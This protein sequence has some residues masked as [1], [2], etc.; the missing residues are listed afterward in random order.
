MPKRKVNKR[1][2][3]GAAY[4]LFTAQGFAKTSMADIAG[5]CGLLKGSIYHYFQSKEDLIETVLQSSLAYRSLGLLPIAYD[6]KIPSRERLERFLMSID[7]DQILELQGSLMIAAVLELGT[8]PRYH[9][10]LSQ[11]FDNWTQAVTAIIGGESGNQPARLTSKDILVRIQ[12]GV[13]LMLAYRDK[14]FLERSL[15]DIIY[16]TFGE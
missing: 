3:V 13:V 6:D 15:Q 2:I 16:Q 1:D 9:P 10:H 4:R 8:Q 14:Y 11:F 5:S 7:L 12:G